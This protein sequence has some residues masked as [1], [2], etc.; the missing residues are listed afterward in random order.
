M[1][2][3]PVFV[4][5]TSGDVLV[6]TK[7]VEFPWVAGLSASQKAKRVEALH[8]SAARALGKTNILEVSTKSSLPLGV[9]L[10]AFNLMIETRKLKQLFSVESAYQSSK[11]F[12]NGG[13][14]L[15]SLQADSQTAKADQSL[16]LSGELIGFRFFGVEWGI[17]P[18]T[19]F[20]DWLYISALSKHKQL[21]AMLEVYSAFT[22]IEFNP[23]RSVNCQ[24]YSVAVYCALNSRRLLGEAL[25]S[26]ESFL[27]IVYQREINNSRQ[28]QGSQPE[29]QFS[30]I[31]D[32]A[33]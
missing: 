17:E 25:A 29:L 12:R 18:I 5:T 3:R 9:S 19:A 10:S 22:D 14:F 11:I 28:N 1:A 20:Y 8:A 4:P 21:T 24:A 32:I 2:T 31:R 23:A 7:I 6:E 30:E 33:E 16:K 27:K 13:P 15:D 26:K